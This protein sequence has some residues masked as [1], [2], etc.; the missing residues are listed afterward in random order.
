MGD[1]GGIGPEVT[2]KAVSRVARAFPRVDFLLFGEDWIINSVRRR[3]PAN[4]HIKNMSAIKQSQFKPGRISSAHGKAAWLY[5][6]QAVV[7]L[8]DA[9]IQ[10]LVTA[11][12]CKEAIVPFDRKFVGHT[13]FLADAAGIDHV[14]MLFVARKMRTIIVTRHVPLKNVPRLITQDLVYQTIMLTAKGL[15]EQ[16]KIRQPRIAVCGL[17]PHAGEN[18]LL[19]REDREVIVPAIQAARRRRVKAEGPFAADTLFVAHNAAAY[20]C[21]V[22]MYHDQGLI[23]I[24]T[25]YFNELVNMTIGLPYVRTSPA[26]GT[27]FDI[28]GKNQADPS[29]MA[30]AIR[31]AARLV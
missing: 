23:P 20:D 22:A 14:G 6:K 9:E 4:C 10:A 5:L 30:E 1:P 13:E 18:G 3:L 24:K 21:I 29:S 8:K 17:N 2:A 19:G 16:F 27:A 26:H 11:P 25:L 31:L 28:A 12:V 7:A 15:K